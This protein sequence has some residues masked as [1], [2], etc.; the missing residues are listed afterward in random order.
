MKRYK[1]AA[2]FPGVP[3]ETAGGPL[4]AFLLARPGWHDRMKVA[5]ALGLT[6]REVRQQAE[7]S[8]G[9]VIFGSRKGWGLKHSQHAD[10]WERRA[11]C[12]ELRRRAQSH[13]KRAAEIEGFTP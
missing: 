3:I 5:A 13:L 4:E 6:D 10:A 2:L 1:Q 9:L 8:G 12:H 7:Y 11:C